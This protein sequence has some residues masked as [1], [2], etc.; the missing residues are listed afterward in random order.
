MP[1]LQDK[2][3]QE[4]ENS[5]AEEQFI[6]QIEDQLGRLRAARDKGLLQHPSLLDLDEAAEANVKYR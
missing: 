3:S 4:L 5:T 6:I 1:G 2:E